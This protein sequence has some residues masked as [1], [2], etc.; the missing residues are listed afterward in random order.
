MLQ[1]T[2][3]INIITGKEEIQ[4]HNAIIK[5]YSE[6]GLDAQKILYLAL[7]KAKNKLPDEIE[8]PIFFSFKNYLS[9]TRNSVGGKDY[10]LIRKALTELM[11][12]K[13]FPYDDEKKMDSFHIA[14]RVKYDSEKDWFSI[15]LTDDFVFYLFG[16]DKCGLQKD[17][18]IMLLNEYMKLKNVFSMKIYALLY[19]RYKMTINRKDSRIK[20]GNALTFSIKLQTFKDMLHGENTDKFPDFRRFKQRVINVALKEINKN[21]NMK[22]E[23]SRKIT[24]NRKVVSLEFTVCLNNNEDEK[25][26]ERRRQ[27]I[28]AGQIAINPDKNFTKEDLNKYKEHFG[29]FLF[30]RLKWIYTNTRLDYYE[31]YIAKNNNLSEEKLKAITT[32]INYLRI[33][34][35]RA[36]RYCR[37]INEQAT[38][39][40]YITTLTNTLLFEKEK[41]EK[42]HTAKLIN[43]LA[44]NFKEENSFCFN[45]TV[46]KSPIQEAIYNKLIFVGK[47]KQTK[48]D[49][50]KELAIELRNDKLIS[51]SDE[52]KLI[53]YEANIDKQKELQKNFNDSIGKFLV[54]KISKL[55]K[56]P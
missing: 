50:I 27:Y 54:K 25:L 37:K 5:A 11:D 1:D 42:K 56:R 16:L 4:I 24:E 48:H 32:K 49:E 55:Y 28:D 47:I 12:T 33:A 2:P 18:T 39:D 14:K 23:L 26:F 29:E 34:N 6:L 13:L 35:N 9:Y 44:R 22:V 21:T 51:Y 36:E 53:N 19:A 30:N 20:N 46:W 40:K 17:Y 38:D 10:R 52:A 7:S 8:E 3:K 41:N 31:S 45:N 15:S 43:T